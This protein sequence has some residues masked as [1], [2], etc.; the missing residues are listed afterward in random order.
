[1]LYEL[2]DGAIIIGEETLASLPK[3][4]QK[5]LQE[6]D[7]REILEYNFGGAPDIMVDVLQPDHWA[8]PK[9]LKEEEE[10]E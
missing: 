7:S 4:L 2:G 9:I 6:K 1:M 8:I 5:Q 10:E 3:Q